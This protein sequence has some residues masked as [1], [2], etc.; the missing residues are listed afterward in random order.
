[1]LK[2]AGAEGGDPQVVDI[3]NKQYPVFRQFGWVNALSPSG[4]G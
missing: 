2:P 4:S 3:E 1:M